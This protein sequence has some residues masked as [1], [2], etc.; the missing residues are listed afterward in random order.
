MECSKPSEAEKYFA[1]AF[2]VEPWRMKGLE[3]Y[4]SCLWH[5]KKEA[6]LTK[7]AY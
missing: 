2:K 3:Y 1:E 6:E 5:L 7:L 4:S